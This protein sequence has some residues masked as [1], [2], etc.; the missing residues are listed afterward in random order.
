MSPG[1][2]HG[3][4][5]VA[6]PRLV[7]EPSVSEPLKKTFVPPFIQSAAV[8]LSNDPLGRTLLVFTVAN[9]SA[10]ISTRARLNGSGTWI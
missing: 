1:L 6:A 3:S 5:Q 8:R 9:I 4:Q 10:L 7:S 2:Y